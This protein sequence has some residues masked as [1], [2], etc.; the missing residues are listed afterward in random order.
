M[1]STAWIALGLVGVALVVVG[2]WARSQ[3]AE[4]RD[5]DPGLPTAEGR[6]LVA[7]DAGEVA[8][9]ELP[10]RGAPPFEVLDLAEA[11]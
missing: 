2:L 5:A 9:F 6:L 10:V 7:A 4:S 3:G 1:T 8:S 11:V